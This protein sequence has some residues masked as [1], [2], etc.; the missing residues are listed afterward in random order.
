MR[1][2]VLAPFAALLSACSAGAAAPASTPPAAAAP[3]SAPDAAAQA[4]PATTSFNCATASGEDEKIVCADPA[5]AALDRQLASVYA[6]ALAAPGADTNTL[7]ATQR[8]WVKGRGDC[9]KADDKPAC[10]RESYLTRLVELQI[11]SGKVIV[12][13]PVEYACDDA[14]KPFTVV[15]YNDLDPKAAVITWGDDQAI[16][17][18][19]PSASGIRYGRDGLDFQ[20]HQGVATVDFWGNK[21]SCKPRS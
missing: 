18:P 13:T 19:K 9:W 5:L 6:D 10:V 20:E 11:N 14:S 7:K 16:A 4:A 1:L 17:F 12:P 3:A 8:G 21:L 15:F 2:L